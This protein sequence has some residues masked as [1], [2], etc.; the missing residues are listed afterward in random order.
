[1]NLTLSLICGLSRGSMTCHTVSWI[2]LNFLVILTTCLAFQTN[3][4]GSGMAARGFYPPMGSQPDY[5]KDNGMTCP[6]C[7]MYCSG[8]MCT[9]PSVHH[10]DWCLDCRKQWCPHAVTCHG[11]D[12]KS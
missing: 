2:F 1:M 10:C 11:P 5:D 7:H 3:G 6:H 12:Y 9:G 8:P 4:A